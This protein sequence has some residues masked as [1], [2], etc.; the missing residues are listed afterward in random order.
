METFTKR[1]TAVAQATASAAVNAADVQ[2]TTPVFTPFAPFAMTETQQTAIAE[3]QKMIAEQQRAFAERQATA[4][5]NAVEA[6]RN[7]AEQMAAAS[8]APAPFT[9]PIAPGAP[10]AMPEVPEFP[11]P[12]ELSELPAAPSIAGLDRESRRT[13]MRKY[14]QERRNAMRKLMQEQRDATLQERD[15]Y[16]EQM[17]RIR[18]EV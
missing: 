11:A 6:Q 4:V 17:V 15:K 10:F 12:F 18:P 1:I 16:L 9:R 8:M 5:R 14:M 2:S 3:Y 7:F 13:E